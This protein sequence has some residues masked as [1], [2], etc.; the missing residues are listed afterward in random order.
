[1]TTF[2]V[3]FSNKNLWLFTV[4]QGFT[5]TFIKLFDRLSRNV[6]KFTVCHVLYKNF[7]DEFLWGW[8]YFS[9]CWIISQH[10]FVTLLVSLFSPTPC[11]LLLLNCMEQEIYFVLFCS[12]MFLSEYSHYYGCNNDDN[13]LSV[14]QQLCISLCISHAH[15][16]IIIKNP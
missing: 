6:L 7:L 4:R 16:Q 1:M 9:L 15:T 11:V 8:S 14:K 13:I 12:L 5:C 3:S 2:I 10:K